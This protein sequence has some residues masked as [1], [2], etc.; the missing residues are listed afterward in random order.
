MSSAAVQHT[1][2]RKS[3]FTKPLAALASQPRIPLTK[4]VQVAFSRSWT[5][6]HYAHY[7]ELSDVMARA[8]FAIRKHA[9]RE[10]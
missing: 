7:R 9:T 10:S 6:G 5:G 3:L 4:N 8:H 2:N 1:P